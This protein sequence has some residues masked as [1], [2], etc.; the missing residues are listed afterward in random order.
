MQLEPAGR[1][2]RDEGRNPM[3]RVIDALATGLGD[4]VGWLA[5]H[6][7]L[8]IV[9]AVLW[10][11]FLAALVLS[12]GSLDQAWQTIRGLPLILQAVAWLLFLPVVGGLWVWETT[13]PF[14]ARIIVVLGLAWFNL[15]VLLPRA[16][17]AARP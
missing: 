1:T 5:D 15:I 4:G 10:A 14:L 7:V 3:E 11:G 16:A 6:G 8:F 2:A 17:Q 9:F 13:W 12:Q